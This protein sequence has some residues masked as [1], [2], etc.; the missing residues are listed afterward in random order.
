MSEETNLTGLR[1]V[2]LQNVQSIADLT[3][4]FEQKGVYRLVGDNEIGKSA[5]L[6]GIRALFH[7]VSR[8]SYK[9]YISDWATSFVVEGWFYDGGYVKLSRGANDFY[10]WSIPSGGNLVEKTDGKVPPELQEY[11]NLYTENDKSRITLNF[12]LQGDILPF[13]DTTASDNYWLSQKAFGTNILLNASKNLKSEN[14][15]INKQIKRTMED[16]A[17]DKDFCD[18]MANEIEIDTFE[19]STFKTGVS[20]VNEEFSELQDLYIVFEKESD[21]E[22]NKLSFEQIP[23]LSESEMFGYLGLANEYNTLVKFRN[24]QKELERK[25]SEYTLLNNSLDNFDIDSLKVYEAECSLLKKAFLQESKNISDNNLLDTILSKMPEEEALRDLREHIEEL[26]LINK[27]FNQEVKNNKDKV[28]LESILKRFP[29]EQEMDSITETLSI[30]KAQQNL[31][32]KTVA[33]KQAIE[34][35]QALINL[36]P[37]KDLNEC[38]EQTD[39]LVLSNTYKEKSIEKH[40]NMN[41][42]NEVDSEILNIESEIQKIKEEQKVCPVCGSD[43]AKIH[44]HQ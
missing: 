15:E 3:L 42:L 29:D 38:I 31:L 33:N 14:S 43:I 32:E 9:E 44:T 24:I 30:L 17:K 26:N 39:I 35:V 13:V 8:N 28:V 41:K 22:K 19:L 7:N 11:F 36:L 27:L 16:I 37:E 21:L 2:R 12:N 20:V 25:S 6:R 10:E 40:F 5:I 34:K 23:T 4:D 18:R 1:R